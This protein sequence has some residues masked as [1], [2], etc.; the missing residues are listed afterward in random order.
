MAKIITFAICA[1]AFFWFF[2]EVDMMISGYFYDEK[3][4]FI[5]N[6]HIVTNIIYDSV[7][8]FVIT[9]VLLLI[10]NIIGRFFQKHTKIVC[11]TKKLLPNKQAYFL[12]IV[13][14]IGPGLIVHQGFK[15]YYERPRPKHIV[16][17]GG[18]ELY[19]LPFERREGSGNKSFVS[20]HAAAAFYL[21]AFGF[22]FLG[23]KRKL[24]YIIGI[25]YG[26]IAGIGRIAQGKHFTSDIVFSGIITLLVIHVIFWIM[27][28]RKKGSKR[29]ELPLQE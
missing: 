18:A 17:F 14:I 10:M 24:F 9:S 12:L 22:L 20:G 6:D 15:D 23:Y 21:S 3:D 28:E 8:V 16:E 26:L 29:P 19:A 2:P 25:S 5:Y 1:A 7:E 13:L 4:G 11:D 27:F